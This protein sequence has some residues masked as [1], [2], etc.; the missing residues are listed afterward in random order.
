MHDAVSA[1]LDSRGDESTGWSLA[2]KILQRARLGQG[3]K[4][5]D[6]V[7]LVFRDMTV[8][9]GPWIGGLYPNLFAANPPF[10]IDGNFRYVEGIA[11]SLLQSH[12][13]RIDLLPALPGGTPSGTVLGLVAR[14]GIIV[15]L[16]WT[17][18]ADGGHALVE[19][20]LSATS[21]FAA[22]R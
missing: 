22:G 2:W 14:P 4:V 13:G 3:E 19:A 18:D 10:Q 11:E 16:S 6:L 7:K 20:R 12:H 5:E 9:R 8:D 15:D 1:T 17:T 21:P